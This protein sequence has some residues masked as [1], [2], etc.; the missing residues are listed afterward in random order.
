[1]TRRN[2]CRNCLGRGSGCTCST[3]NIALG[4]TVR[5]IALQAQAY[6]FENEA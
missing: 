1:M 5:M 6:L 3:G 2:S 4:N